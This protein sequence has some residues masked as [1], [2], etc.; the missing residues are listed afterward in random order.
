MIPEALRIG[1]KLH[2]RPL[3]VGDTRNV[4]HLRKTSGNEQINPKREV[5]G[6][7]VSKAIGVGLAKLFGTRLMSPSAMDAGHVA[8]RFNVCFAGF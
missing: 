4:E 5:M 8:I 6:A 2:W 7:A 3:E 1:P